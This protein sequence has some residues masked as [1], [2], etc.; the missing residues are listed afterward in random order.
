MVIALAGRR[1]DAT[2]EQSPRFPLR[3]VDLVRLR[4]RVLF[5]GLCVQSLVCSA[6]CGADLLALDVA[7]QLGI[8]RRVVL[9]FPVVEFRNASVVDRAGDWAKHYDRALKSVERTEEIVILNRAVDDQKAYAD[10][11][12]TILDHALFIAGELQSEVM[13]VAVW[14]CNPRS[15]NDMTLNFLTA[16]RGMGLR[17]SEVLTL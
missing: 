17:I 7:A 15:G 14:D 11:N 3:N 2:D 6:G 4:I 10:T 16:A 13:A 1:I 5:E 9:P 8:R 12:R